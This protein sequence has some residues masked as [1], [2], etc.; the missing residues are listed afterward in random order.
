MLI[1]LSQVLLYFSITSLA[2]EAYII[3]YAPHIH[4]VV[5]GPTDKQDITEHVKVT[6]AE[7]E[8]NESTETPHGLQSNA[9]IHQ[10]RHH[11]VPVVNVGYPVKI[12]SG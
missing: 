6:S 3:S 7:L 12:L 5:E 1:V 9:F 8:Q 10:V 4:R 11:L 2:I